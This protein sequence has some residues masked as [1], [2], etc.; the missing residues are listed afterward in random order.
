MKYANG[1]E[2]NGAWSQGRKHGKGVYTYSDGDYYDGQWARDSAEGQ[3][4]SMIK[5][6]YF[7]G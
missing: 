4:S 3:G 5:G 7:E 6:V 2:Y 1:D